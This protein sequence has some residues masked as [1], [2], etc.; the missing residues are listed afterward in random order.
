MTAKEIEEEKEIK[1]E[2]E[3]EKLQKVVAICGVKNS[4]KTTLLEKLVPA[5]KERGIKTA[6][7]KHDGHR[8][9][10]D[11]EGTDS[12]R[13]LMAGAMGA[14]VFDGEKFQV[15]KKE[16]VSERE[17]IRLF[18]EADLILLEG[19]KD[20]SYPK[21]EVVR[22]GISENPVSMGP[23]LALVTDGPC[24]LPGVPSFGLEEIQPICDL[25][26]RFW[27]G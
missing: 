21:I 14:A 9:L 13:I 27:E 24:R 6:L 22:R 18:P 3:I 2:I 5:L 19:F 10:P 12:Y 15:V 16:E 4:G 11:R 1:K 25:L 26:V 17:L 8:F 20:S 7:I 23:H